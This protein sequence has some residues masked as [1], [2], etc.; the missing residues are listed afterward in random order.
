MQLYPEI[1]LTRHKHHPWTT[2]SGRRSFFDAVAHG[3]GLDPLVADSWAP[4][5]R[6]DV[7]SCKVCAPQANQNKTKIDSNE[8]HC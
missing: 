5:T 1:G 3:K 2:I 4:I 8:Q 6:A 7:L